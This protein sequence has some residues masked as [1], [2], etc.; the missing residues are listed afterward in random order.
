[1]AVKQARSPE[2]L[3]SLV[4]NVQQLR[5]ELD[6]ARSMVQRVEMALQSNEAVLAELAD[7]MREAVRLPSANDAFE[8]VDRGG[9]AGAVVR[10]QAAV[11]RWVADGTLVTSGVFAEA[12]G[13]TRQALDQAVERGELFSVKHGNKRFYPAALM[14]LGRA[15]VALVSKS[16]GHAAPEEKLVFWLRPQGALAGRTAVQAVAEG[17]GAR[18]AQLAQDWAEERGLSD[19]VA[20]T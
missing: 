10:G 12:C 6:T 16:L 13:V 15:D 8:A 19:A 5:K 17:K 2:R 9:L 3:S 20:T 7:A 18:V 14:S 4:R 1:M 11:A